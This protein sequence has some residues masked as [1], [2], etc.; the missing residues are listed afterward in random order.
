M[1][2]LVGL[3]RFE[4]NLLPSFQGV[5]ELVFNSVMRRA[6][7][8]QFSSRFVDSSVHRQIPDAHKKGIFVK[9]PSAKDFVRSRPAVCAGWKLLHNHLA[10]HSIQTT[11]TFWRRTSTVRTMVSRGDA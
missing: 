9:D 5:D 6:L 11:M 1:Q 3:K 2:E 8:I 10:S 7:L 4:M